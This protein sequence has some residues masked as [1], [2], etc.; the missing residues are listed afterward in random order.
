[1]HV[2]HIYTS[3]YTQT[4]KQQD[5]QT[6]RQAD[7][8]THTYISLTYINNKPCHIY[9]PVTTIYLVD[10]EGCDDIQVFMHYFDWFLTY[11]C[12]TICCLLPHCLTFILWN[13]ANNT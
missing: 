6:D 5:R 12:C 9:R 7:T 2:Q 13:N 1:M 10:T 11:R 3:D 4:T 8:Q